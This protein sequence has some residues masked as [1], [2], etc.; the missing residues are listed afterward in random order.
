MSHL[1]NVWFKVTDLQVTHGRGCRVTTVERRRVPRLR[2]RHRRQLDGPRPP[3]GGCCDR[4]PGGTIHPR[5][6]QRLHARPR[7]AVG[8]QARRH[9]ARHDRHV[10]LRQLRGRD[11]G[12]RGEARQAGHAPPEHHR[13]PGLVPRAYAHGD[14]DDHVQDRVPGGAR[15]VA[16][17]CVR[18]PVPRP[19]RG[20]P[21]R[22]RSTSR[23]TAFDR[24]LLAETAPP[25]PRP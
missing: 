11:H 15:A 9:H 13:V 5:P 14:G 21:G 25:R 3:E 8:L 22:R 19:A 7:R 24:L 23:S 4:R 20:R 16:V 10:L 18:E 2:G 12:G 1:S 17:G 6:D